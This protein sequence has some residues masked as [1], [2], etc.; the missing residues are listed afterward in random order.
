M[1]REEFLVTSWKKGLKPILL[2]T[3]L[4]FCV[5]FL[6]KAVFE[7]GAWRIITI[8]LLGIGILMIT[9]NLLGEL[10]KKAIQKIYSRLPD[11]AKLWIRIIR[12]II[13]YLSPII[14]G[15]IIYHFWMKDSISGVL[16]GGVLLIQ[17]IAE[18]IK[19]EKESKA[20]DNTG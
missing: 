17:R 14:L 19:K 13:N 16:V 7:N 18:I 12:Q 20:I 9:A 8:A 6:Y 5:F 1:D 11:S 3:L 2:I 4:I 10:F 15:I